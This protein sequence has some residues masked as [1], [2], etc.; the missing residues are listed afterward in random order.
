MGEPIYVGKAKNLRE[1]LSYYFQEN[2]LSDRTRTMVNESFSLE[3][4]E[5][6]SEVD[7]LILEADI[8][9]RLKPKYNIALKDDKSY[10]LVKVEN[11]HRQSFPRV[12][13]VRR[14]E[15][16]AASYFGPFPQGSSIKKVL[17]S[18]RKM[19]NFRDCSQ[20]KFNKYR[21]L[22]RGC[23]YFDLGLCQAPCAGMI[24]RFE[25]LNSLKSIRR[26][27]SEGSENL[28]KELTDSMIRYSQ[29]LDFEKAEEVKQKLEVIKK[30]REIKFSPEDYR[31]NPFLIRDRRRLENNDLAE[32]VNDKSNYRL[33]A[34]KDGF[35]VE[36]YDI[37][38]L[39]GN[40][41]TASM[42]VFINGLPQKEEYKRFKVKN[43]KGINDYQM[44][45]EVLSRRSKHDNWPK[46]DLVLVDGGAGQAKIAETILG[47]FFS[48]PVIGLAKRLEQ[49]YFKGRYYR[50]AKNQ[51][52]MELLV[53]IRDES[54]RFAKKYHQLLRLKDEVGN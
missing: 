54:H 23:L 28:E 31:Q 20:T 43:V 9:K 14:R 6:A 48:I 10:L 32:F 16:D 1:R 26:F 45:A 52:I 50:I 34:N 33:N 38:N 18:L 12:L 35:R 25:Y 30:I 39:N 51:P 41:P 15:P 11:S 36:A 21:K 24:G 17:R 37:S 42:V 3:T 49:I 7:A 5:T 47:I 27:L 22:G 29:I 4:I 19:F 2:L 40:Q 13:L 46:P 53:R 44:M 8:I